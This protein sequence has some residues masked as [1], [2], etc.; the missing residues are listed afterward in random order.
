[1]NGAHTS[2]PPYCAMRSADASERLPIRDRL[3]E[4]TSEEGASE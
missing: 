1:M 4:V 2:T 3:S